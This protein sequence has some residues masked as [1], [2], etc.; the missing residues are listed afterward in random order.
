[1][2][3]VPLKSLL[4]NEC[5]HGS[6]VNMH[7]PKN[8]CVYVYVCVCVCVCVCVLWAFISVQFCCSIM[9]ICDP[10]DCSM[11]GFPV[12]NQLPELVQTHVH[13]VS[14]AIQQS[15]LLS[16]PSPPAFN[17][18]QH[19]G[20]FQM[21]QFFVSG[22]QIIG[23]SASASVLPMNTQDWFPLGLTGWISLQSKRL[24]GVSSNTTVQKH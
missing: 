24:S 6:Q 5:L 4:E 7:T 1:M 9:S 18:S 14:D 19:Q 23:V 11:L 17:L 12:Q 21:S 2:N 20:I 13:W 15:H 22:G 10:R 8:I 3:R 16:S